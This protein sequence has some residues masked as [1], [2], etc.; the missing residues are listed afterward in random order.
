MSPGIAERQ[1][2]GINSIKNLKIDPLVGPLQT[3]L[4]YG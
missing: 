3:S 2:D 4:K 1:G